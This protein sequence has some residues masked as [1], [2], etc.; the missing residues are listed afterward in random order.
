MS[1]SPRDEPI[2][3]DFSNMM[4]PDI[5]RPRGITEDELDAMAGRAAEAV[6][7][8]NGRRKAGATNN[9]HFEERAIA[10]LPW[11]DLP[12]ERFELTRINELAAR[13]REAYDNF[14]VLGIGGSALGNAALVS[15]LC[16]PLYN[17]LD[18]ERR[19]G[20]R[21]YVLDNID[22]VQSECLFDMLDMDRTAFNVITKSGYTAETLSHLLVVRER[23][24]RAVGGDAHKH[25]IATTDRSRGPLR[26]MAREEG[27]ETLTVPDGVGGRFS[28][29]SPVGLLT[30]A[31]AGIDVHALLAGAA[32]MDERCQSE[33]LREN[34]AL[35]NA[36]LQYLCDQRGMCMSVLM[37]YAHSLY[38]VADWHR[39]LWAESL[40]KKLDRT[41]RAVH[42]G[43]TPVKA[44]GA[45][46]QH[47]QVQLYMEGP[48]DKVI[49]FFAV[50]S[51][52]VTCA[53]PPVVDAP[54]GVDYLAGHTLNELLEAERIATAMALTENGRPNCTIALPRLCPHTVGQLLYMLEV[55][56]ALAGELYNINA[57]NQPGV[58]RGKKIAQAMLGRQGREYDDIR[59]DI[60]MRLG[61]KATSVV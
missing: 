58:D 34:P 56:T 48:Y 3:L 59:T 6:A 50:E 32:A 46:D 47:S 8:L 11:M 40:G 44:L 60:N 54:E 26:Q 33:R 15:A 45:T 42:C 39:Q 61:K 12:R 37:P 38:A 25:I 14:V 35:M 1:G 9:E 24:R 29:L 5:P 41:G 31:V 27:Y 18:R 2:R 28:V 17:E 7:A 49:T 4:A 13:V 22:P 23:L 53:M 57:F 19:G 51:F 52:G 10:D 21:V 20:P 30:A 16:P 43:P 36:V 55:Q